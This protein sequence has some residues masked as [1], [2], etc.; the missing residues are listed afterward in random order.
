MGLLMMIPQFLYAA[1]VAI[2]LA[3][4]IAHHKSQPVPSPG[5][6]PTPIIQQRNKL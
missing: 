1:V 2:G 3:L 4:G 6:T 5:S